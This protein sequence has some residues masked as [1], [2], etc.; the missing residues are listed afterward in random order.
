MCHSIT[1]FNH[2][3]D[4]LNF[5]NLISNY[6]CVIYLW[7]RIG[8]LW[9]K[10]NT[11]IMKFNWRSPIFLIMEH[12]SNMIIYPAGSSDTA[13]SCGEAVWKCPGFRLA[14]KRPSNLRRPRLLLAARGETEG[15]SL[16]ALSERQV[17]EVEC[18]RE[19]LCSEF[20]WTTCFH[21]CPGLMVLR[22]KLP[23]SC[24]SMRTCNTSAERGVNPSCHWFSAKKEDDDD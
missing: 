12:I 14:E 18:G 11:G 7:I 24:E 15:I 10:W 8:C 3:F 16:S 21:V 6:V 1:V 17:G 5:L 22:A 9:W 4:I 20:R 23:F 13:G 19:L 2:W